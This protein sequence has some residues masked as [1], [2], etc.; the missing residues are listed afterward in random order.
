[1]LS[2]LARRILSAIVSASSVRLIRDCSDGSDLDIFLVPS[3]S[4]MTRVASPRIIGSGSGNSSTA[5][6]R[7]NEPAMSRASSRCCFWSSPTGTWV[8]L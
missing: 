7:L 2:D 6:R 5:K 1:M 4:D 3:R 8:A